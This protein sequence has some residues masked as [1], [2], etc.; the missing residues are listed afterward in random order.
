MGTTINSYSVGFGMDASNYIQG[1]NI[2]RGA[3]R[4]LIKDIE[5]ART[6]TEK[7]AIEQDRLGEAYRKG[8][9]DIYTYNRLLSSKKDQLG[10]TTTAMNP[11]AI[12][13]SAIAVAGAAAV[14]SGVVFVNH[15]RSV[16]AEIDETVKAGIKLGLS[17]NEISQL[18]FAASEIGGM[19]AGTVDASVKKMMINIAKAVEGDDKA[20]EAF[21][22]IGLD[23]GE[24]MKA[25]PVEAVKQIADRMQGVG[26]QAERLKLA[27]ELFGKSG[28]DFV[29]TLAA[30]RD[31]IDESAS[32]QERW[33]SLTI[34]QTMGVEANNDAWGRIFTIV[35]GV[36]NE[37]AAEFA[38]AMHLVADLILDSA[39]SFGGVDSAVRAV[40]DTTVYFAGVLKDVYELSTLIQTTLYNT[41]TLNFSEVGK[42]FDA[43]MD[44]S[45]GEQAL[46]ALYDKRAELDQAA[47]K[48]QK[49]LDERRK[50]LVDDDAKEELSKKELAEQKRLQNLLDQEEKRRNQMAKSAIDAA[51]KEF[52]ER[53]KRQKKMQADIAKGP[54]GGMEA[55]SA[56]AARF[57]ADQANAAIA[58]DVVPDQPTVG[59][60]QL[61]EEAKRQSDKMAG[62]AKE[63]ENQTALL[64]KLVDKPTE[65][66]RAR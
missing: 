32:F 34:A 10:L 55:D 50:T 14:A 8:A 54:G 35:E 58:K 56:E 24:L 30:G 12:G 29:D 31:A 3:T 23:A 21:A 37:L 17:Y 62:Q 48:R 64:R 19:D 45:S 28:T 39:E 38:P 47:A 20:K 42:S 5:G 33:N 7:L 16:Q 60:A 44:F 59:E 57:M 49:E 22:K 46:Q 52:D 63:L 1:A 40:V 6:P 66:A 53:E 65:L 43:A 13:L 4:A 15:L 11:Y 2:S 36:S 26:S 27:M 9:I 61:L 25:G 41:A 51:R 18:R